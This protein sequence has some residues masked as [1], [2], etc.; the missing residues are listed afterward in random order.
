MSQPLTDQQVFTPRP[1]EDL[2]RESNGQPNN[3]PVIALESVPNLDPVPS[4]PPPAPTPPGPPV[5]TPG[6]EPEVLPVERPTT[7]EGA[8]WSDAEIKPGTELAV[9][10]NVELAAWTNDEPWEHETIEFR[11]DQLNIRKPTYQ[12]LAGLSLSSSKYV[13]MTTRNDIT[14]LFIARHLSPQTYDRVFSRLMDPDDAEY[15]VETIGELMGAIVGNQ[16]DAQQ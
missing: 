5:A 9:P 7:T 2:V 11:G 15:T 10:S 4:A 14:G 6:P 12:A 1:V 16:G 8:D 13:K 3:A